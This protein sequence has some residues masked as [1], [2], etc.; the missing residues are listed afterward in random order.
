MLRRSRAPLHPP[1]QG[2]RRPADPVVSLALV[3]VLGLAGCIAVPPA[4]AIGAQRAANC[5]V[6]RVI[7]GD[8]VT[9]WCPGTGT[10]RVRI[11]GLDAPETSSPHCASE[12]AAGAAA[13]RALRAMLARGD[14]LDVARQGTDRYGRR[15]AVLR[16]D[17]A[18]VADRMIGAGHARAYGGG[19]R[20]GWCG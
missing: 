8:T 15:L 7:D 12:A 6:Q 19:P 2:L 1:A 16:L 4:P 20:Q 5:R 17:G 10:E 18:T 14:R 11:L 3:V 9:L 13:T